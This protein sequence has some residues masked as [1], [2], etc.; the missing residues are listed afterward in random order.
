MRVVPPS[1]GLRRPPLPLPHVIRPRAIHLSSAWSRLPS[2]VPRRPYTRPHCITS[3]LRPPP[4]HYVGATPAS[5]HY[6]GPT[7][8][9]TASPPRPHCVPSA[10][11]PPPFHYVGAT[12]ASPHYVGSTSALTAVAAPPSATATTPALRPP[13]VGATPAFTAVHRRYVHFPRRPRPL[14]SPRSALTRLCH[15]SRARHVSLGATSPPIALDQRYARPP[16]VTRSAFAAFR[17]QRASM[18]IRCVAL[19]TPRPV[20]SSECRVYVRTAHSS[21]LPASLPPSCNTCPASLPRRA[22]IART[23]HALRS[24]IPPLHPQ[25]IPNQPCLKHTTDSR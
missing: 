24:A 11:H 19:P 25:I 16:D 9:L 10:L 22:C 20:L 4:S 3:A 21:L 8:A 17:R 15:S 13:Y 5:P 2:R 7:S 6:V 12:P 14:F 1:Y 23:A 18:L